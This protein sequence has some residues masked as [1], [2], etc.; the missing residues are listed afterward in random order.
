MDKY[1]HYIIYPF[2]KGIPSSPQ[3]RAGAVDTTAGHHSITCHFMNYLQV[4]KIFLVARE[5]E[6][7]D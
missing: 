3:R 2:V 4:L 1:S 7:L 6:N 5:R